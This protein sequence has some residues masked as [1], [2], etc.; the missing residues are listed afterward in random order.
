M[1]DPIL[2]NILKRSTVKVLLI[3]KLKDEKTKWRKIKSDIQLRT[4]CKQASVISTFGKLKLLIYAIAENCNL[5]IAKLAL[6]NKV[7]AKHHTKKMIDTGSKSLIFSL[8]NIVNNMFFS[9]I[10][11][12][13]NIAIKSHLK[14]WKKIIKVQKKI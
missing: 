6:K 8:E 10:I 12:Q 3:H 14:T 2:S 9:A 5:K 11:H 7:Q 4:T 13:L 1:L